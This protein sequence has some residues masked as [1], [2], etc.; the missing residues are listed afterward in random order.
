[1]ARKKAT[2]TSRERAMHAKAWL[3]FRKTYL[4]TQVRLAEIAGVSRRTIQMIESARSLPH[5][6][7]QL[8]F[9]ELQATYSK[10]QA[11]A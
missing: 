10:E 1:M 3:E 4:M 6:S 7:T 2:S 8:R 9:R 5:F 11:A